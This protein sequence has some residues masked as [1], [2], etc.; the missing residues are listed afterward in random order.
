MLLMQEAQSAAAAA[1]AAAEPPLSHVLLAFSD[2]CARAGS[3]VSGHVVVLAKQQLQ[4]V[5][6]SVKF[7]GIEEVLEFKTKNQKP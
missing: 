7:T 3:S 1:A 2:N 6:I 4:V 5:D